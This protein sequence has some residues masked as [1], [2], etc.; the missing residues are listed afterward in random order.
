M[1]VRPD[2]EMTASPLTQ[3]SITVT[4]SQGHTDKA[5]H[6]VLKCNPVQTLVPPDFIGS[7]AVVFVVH[8]YIMNMPS[9]ILKK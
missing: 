9:S 2:T 4:L 3:N 5:D 8:A 1:Q 6:V 7:D